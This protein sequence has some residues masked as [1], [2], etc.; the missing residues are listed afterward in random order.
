[1]ALANTNL[2]V[3]ELGFFEIKNN[4]KNFLR[5]KPEFTDFDFEGSTMS[6][7]LDVLAYNT[8]YNSF[9]LN[10]VANETFLDSAIM[11]ESV[12]SISKMLNYTPRSARSARAQLSISFTPNDSPSEIVIPAYTKFSTTIDGVV[13]Y[14]STLA[15]YVVQSA[16][17]VYQK[18]IDIYEGVVLSNKY[19]VN[20]TRKLYEIPVAGVDTST[21]TVEVQASSTSTTKTTYTLVKDA[22][23]V[24]ATSTVYYLQKNS[25]GFYEIYF[26]DGILG[27]ALDLNNIVTIT[28]RACNGEAPNNAY[29]FSKIGYTGYNKDSPTVKYICNIV[30]VTLR[31]REGQDEETIDSIK[32][33]APRNFEIQ[34][35]L[36]TAADYKNFIL[37]NYSDIE[38]VNVWGGE[39]HNPPL[40]GKSII[41][42]KPVTG[43]VITENRKSEIINDIKKFNPMS[44]DPAIIDPVFL[45]VKPVVQVNYNS[46]QSLLSVDELFSKIAT[47]VQNFETTELGV[48][49]NRF[50]Q[51]KFSTMVDNSDN[52]IESNQ[53]SI[54]IEK[55]FA[56]VL[57]SK[58]N[59]NVDFQNQLYCPFTEYQGCISSNGFEIAGSDQT[60]YLDDDGNGTLRLYYLVGSTKNYYDNDV[61]T[62]DYLNGTLSMKSFIFTDYDDEVVISAQPNAT[63]IYSQ[64]NQIILLSNPTF[65]MFD[66]SKS[67]LIFTDI[68]QVIGNETLIDVDGIS[69]T[70]TL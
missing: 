12:Y 69:N 34:N 27:K 39:T 15:D 25:N 24:S 67:K 49:G 59:Y 5:A 20:A 10:M 19:T 51:S 46:S 62:V 37:S 14:F 50:R 60:M 63:D 64:N 26:G 57:N 54:T 31:A 11:K 17:G 44:I 29:S 58:F 41:A 33:N 35:R 52:A 48:F 55:R 28:F 61:G 45:F 56:P 13:Y 9:Y 47:N 53:V 8:Y 70:V 1:M 7:L 3:S 18:N 2:Q 36:I 16:G 68:V 40:Y 6:T 38:A 23:E 66:T 43:F 32:F 30:S 21:M 65:N 22:T 4:L 42:V